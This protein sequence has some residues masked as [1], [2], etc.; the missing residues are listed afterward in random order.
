M[1]LLS[2]LSLFLCSF[3]FFLFSCVLYCCCCYSHSYYYSDYCYCLASGRFGRSSAGPSVQLLRAKG[4]ARVQQSQ[5]AQKPFI[6][7]FTGLF[8]HEGPLGFVGRSDWSW[9]FGLDR[10]ARERNQKA[11]QILASSNEVTRNSG[12]CQEYIYTHIHI[13]VLFIYICKCEFRFSEFILFAL[14]TRSSVSA[15]TF[16]FQSCPLGPSIREFPTI[17]NHGTI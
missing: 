6:K 15:K 14:Q 10:E 3:S 12:Y 8:L 5:G 2:F 4:L 13:H 9:T 1:S 17:R 11:G 16:G 7:G